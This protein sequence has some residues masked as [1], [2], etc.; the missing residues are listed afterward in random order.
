MVTG[1]KELGGIW[2]YLN[3]SGAMVKGWQTI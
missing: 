3:E 1:W 2:Y